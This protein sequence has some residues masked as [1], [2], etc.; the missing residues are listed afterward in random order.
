MTPLG[1]VAFLDG[2]PGHE[3]QTKGVLAALARLTPIDVTFRTVRAGS[4]TVGL[5]DWIRYFS[6]CIIPRRKRV[7]RPAADLIIGTG[8]YTHIPMLVLK[9]CVGAKA[10]TCMSPAFPLIRK[11]D[12]CFVPRHDRRRSEENIFF[13]T[14]PPNNPG[15]KSGHDP[16]K[17]LILV[18]GIDKKSHRWHTAAVLSQIEAILERESTLTWTISS[19]PRTPL[20]TITKPQQLAAHTADVT[21]FRSESTPAG[22]VEKQ[23]EDNL[24]VWVTA[25]S[26]SMIF[27]ALAAGCRVGILPVEWK[28]KDS[29][30][31]RCIDD[32][33]R[34]GWVTPFDSWQTDKKMAAQGAPLD[35]ATRCAREM[36]KRWWPDRLR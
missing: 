31:K 26:I 2:R 22:W 16:K 25:D 8:A 20:D 19:S 32:L 36:L 28:R 13:T 4:F 10:V 12:L 29:K 15:A 5:K 35:E 9:K 17:G 1:I 11:M 27:E 23:Y 30:F 24:T 3:K 6:G 7:E 18:G 14:G 34:H 33:V 21:V